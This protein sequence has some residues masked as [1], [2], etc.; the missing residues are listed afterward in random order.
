M[1]GVSKSENPLLKFNKCL[2]ECA[3]VSLLFEIGERLF[4]IREQLFEIRKSND[5]RSH[6]SNFFKNKG[7]IESSQNIF[8]WKCPFELGNPG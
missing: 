5:G 8:Q 2:A 6:F 3:M 7:K 4:E 1:D